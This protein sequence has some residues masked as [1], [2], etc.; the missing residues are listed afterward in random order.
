VPPLELRIE[1]V[2]RR[3]LAAALVD[4]LTEHIRTGELT[5]GSKLPTE[6]ELAEAHGVSRTVVRDAIS[7][8]KAAGLVESQQGR[9][10]FVLMMPPATGASALTRATTRADVL[11]L[12]GF[13]TGVESEAAALAAA[14]ATTDQRADLTAKSAQFAA[15]APNSAQSQTADFDLHLAIARATHNRYFPELMESLGPAMI[16]FPAY[17]LGIEDVREGASH[18]TI[19]AEH[20]AI[21]EAIANGDADTARAAMRMHLANSRSRLR[22]LNS[23]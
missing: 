22:S 10:T 19:C 7:R 21:V 12:L 6:Q 23:P 13:R 15:T 8:L 18:A 9:G 2:A 11:D 1:P 5:P 16:A 17:R 20:D 3:S 4:A 14:H